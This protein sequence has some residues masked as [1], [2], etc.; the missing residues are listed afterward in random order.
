MD[1]CT[2]LFA[3]RTMRKRRRAGFHLFF[4]TNI[5]V[6]L[7][8]Y[9]PPAVGCGCQ[10]P[11]AWRF[12]CISLTVAL[13][14]WSDHPGVRPCLWRK[15]WYSD[16]R[17]GSAILRHPGC[18]GRRGDFRGAIS[19]MVWFTGCRFLGGFCFLR[20][21]HVR[22]VWCAACRRDGMGLD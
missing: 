4:W 20:V 3:L 11:L 21:C 14:C 1:G 5:K 7:C 6:S 13:L 19:P 17:D 18:G 10:P 16:K 22:W 15:T 9:A 12:L 2:G 8:A